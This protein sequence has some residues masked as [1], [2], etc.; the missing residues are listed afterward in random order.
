MT[1]VFLHAVSAPG[2]KEGWYMMDK[3]E[4]LDGPYPTKE[5]ALQELEDMRKTAEDYEAMY[6]E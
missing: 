5:R 2:H 1:I 3:H 6:R 4:E